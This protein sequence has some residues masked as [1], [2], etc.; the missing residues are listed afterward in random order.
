M[1]LQKS[2]RLAV[3]D[4]VEAPPGLKNPA[5]RF[6]V[7]MDFCADLNKC[8]TPLQHD[9]ILLEAARHYRESKLC[10][11]DKKRK[12]NPIYEVKWAFKTYSL[13]GPTGLRW[14][15]EA[16][17]LG[18]MPDDEIAKVTA[19]TPGVIAAYRKIFFDVDFFL[20]SKDMI[21]NCVLPLSHG[22]I[23][24]YNAWDYSWKAFATEFGAENFLKYRRHGMKE[25]PRD[26]VDWIKHQQALKSLTM[27][28][29]IMNDT[30]I[31]YTEEAQAVLDTAQKYWKL[32]KEDLEDIP[33]SDAADSFFNR[34]I[35]M[36]Q[37][38]LQSADLKL[39]DREYID[40]KGLTSQ[41]LLT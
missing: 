5:W 27:A 32:L 30:R 22:A 41:Q 1:N 7:A 24:I 36:V 31:A 29:H 26:A 35:P 17:I 10:L 33:K 16:L 39:P 21:Y 20:A 8:I 13:S 4:L 14:T 34:V 23:N 37:M 19:S 11:L 3:H 2:N 28:N 6:V 15:T 12:F 25:L 9:Q 40:I 18:N 38:T